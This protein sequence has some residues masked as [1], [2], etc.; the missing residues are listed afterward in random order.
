MPTIIYGKVK[1]IRPLRC[2]ATSND[3]LVDFN[4]QDYDFVPFSPDTIIEDHQFFEIENY[5][6]APFCPDFLTRDIVQIELNQITSEEIPNLS[7]L[8]LNQGDYCFFQTISSSHFLNQTSWFSLRNFEVS[9][10]NSVIIVNSK[11][12]IVVN[13]ATNSLYFKKLPN[14]NKVFVGIDQLYRAATD[15]EVRTLLEDPLLQLANGMDSNR[16]SIPNRKRIAQVIEEFQIMTAQDRGS[17]IAS[18]QEY[19]QLQFE[20]GSVIIN[21]DKDLKLFIYGLEER[22]YTSAL[23]Q[24]KRIA[25]SIIPI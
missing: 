14:T 19:T 4:L 10:G 5:R 22:Y 23:R 8:V 21:S 18:L 7:Y 12:E 16:V 3:N 1:M 15:D 20:N 17:I 2:I 6:F 9:S 13:I 11:P 25:N 24:Q